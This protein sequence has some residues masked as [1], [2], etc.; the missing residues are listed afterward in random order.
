MLPA[1]T[2][3][4]RDILMDNEA[5]YI[6]VRFFGGLA[7]LVGQSEIKIRVNNNATLGSLL[8]MLQTRLPGV[9]K[10]LSPQLKEGSLNILIDGRYTSF[11]KGLDTDLPDGA[12]VTFLPRIGGG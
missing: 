5:T 7:H 1:R 6:R 12:V 10:K 3:E 11:Y 9:S 2:K 8:A 4:E